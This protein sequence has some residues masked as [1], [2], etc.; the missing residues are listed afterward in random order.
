MRRSTPSTLLVAVLLVAG[1]GAG[2]PDPTG[3]T[4]PPPSEPPATVAPAPASTAGPF[5][6]TDVA[7]LQ[8]TVAMA[9]RLLP[10][11]ELVPARTTDPAWRRLAAQVEATERADLERARRLLADSGAPATNPHEGHDMPGMV[12]AEEVTVLRAATGSPFHRLLAGHLRA[13]L[14]QATRV[15]VAEQRAGSHPATTAMAGAVVRD[16]DAHLTRLD[17]LDRPTSTAP[18]TTAAA[19]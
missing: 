7:W 3:T 16:G 14:A 8:L 6:P 19:R 4:A 18:P 12:T 9:E 1:C 17:R 2:P 11:L 15:A 13:H 5:S 10:V